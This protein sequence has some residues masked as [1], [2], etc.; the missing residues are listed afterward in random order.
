MGNLYLYIYGIIGLAFFVLN[1]VFFKQ[2][3]WGC[4][5]YLVWVPASLFLW[6]FELVWVAFKWVQIMIRGDVK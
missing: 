6:P 5:M 4:F 1:R 2:F 3:N